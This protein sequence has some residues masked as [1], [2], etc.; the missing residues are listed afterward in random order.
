MRAN[1][2]NKAPSR[3][4]NNLVY[5]KYQDGEGGHLTSVKP[6]EDYE[7]N[8]EL[9]EKERKSPHA[10]TKREQELGL[11]S[12]RVAAAGWERSGIRWA[13]LNVPLKRRLQTLMVLL[14]TLS[15]ALTLTW[16]FLD[17]RNP[18]PLAASSPLPHLCLAIEG[19]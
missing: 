15:V 8:L 4:D 12:G 7:Q 13:P 18:T 19:W 9:D 2:L 11:E 5:Q 17:V 10:S 6:P 1:G 14:H 16:F 3:E